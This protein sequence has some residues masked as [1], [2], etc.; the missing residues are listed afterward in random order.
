[1][2]KIHG[3]HN[4]IVSRLLG[5]F[6]SGVLFFSILPPPVGAVS[7]GE[8]LRV[9]LFYSENALPTA[10]LANEVGSGYEFGSYDSKGNFTSVG[11]TKKEKITVCKDANIYYANNSF[12]ESQ[13]GSNQKLIGAYHLQAAGSYGTYRE[14]EAQTK[15]HPHGF[16]AYVNGTYVVRFESYSSLDGANADRGNY[17]NA[18]AVGGSSSCYT[19]VDTLTGE[20]IFE[21]DNGTKAYLGIKPIA[22]NGVDTQTWFKGFQYYGG[23]QYARRGGK[24]LSVINFVSEDLYVSCVL[25][26]EFVLSGSL[27]S[28]KAGAVAVR[29]FSRVATKHSGIGF[30]ICNTTDCQVYRG[31]YRGERADVILQAVNETQ[32][33]CAYSNNTLI[34]TTYFSSSG[35]ATENSELVWGAPFAYLKGKQDPYEASID[36]PG[37]SWSY[38]T[39]PE[40]VQKLLNDRGLDCAT[41][42]KMEVTQLSDLGNVNELTITDSRGE[43]FRFTQDN[44]RILQQ[45]PDVQYMSRNYSITPN[46]HSEVGSTSEGV[47]SVYDGKTTKSMDTVDVISSNGASTVTGEATVIT[48]KGIE[49]IN[50]N[51]PVYDDGDGTG[52]TITGG[53]YGHNVGMSQWGAY[54]MGEQGFTYDEILKFYYTGITVK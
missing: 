13:S 21:Y 16:V 27:E 49:T 34:Q 22:E 31:V 40:D 11:M 12:Y 4:Q 5:L 44:V 37:K 28:L 3:K 2:R 35:G 26:Y 39:T 6:L 53:G 42:T 38:T 1:M 46:G 48:D 32:G 14:A 8:N 43:T 50:K 51:T 30:D 10:N 25:P 47:F 19:V 29:T 18:T 24:D 45:L 17:K 23:F 36:F 7:Q 9:G 33:K 54:A 41:V 15:N 20:I 52:W